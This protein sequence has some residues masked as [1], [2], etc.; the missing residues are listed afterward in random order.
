MTPQILSFIVLLLP[1]ILLCRAEWT[2]QNGNK[3][4][5]SPPPGTVDHSPAGQRR[6]QE[7][8]RAR[9]A[10]EEARHV[11]E[12]R[13]FDE[14][15]AKETAA[16]YAFTKKYKDYINSIGT[17]VKQ[18]Q[19]P[20]ELAGIEARRSTQA[21]LNQT[22]DTLTARYGRGTLTNHTEFSFCNLQ[23]TVCT[24]VP[25]FDTNRTVRI[26]AYFLDGKVARIVYFCE[27]YLAFSHIMSMSRF[28]SIWYGIVARATLDANA[29][30]HTWTCLYNT[31]SYGIDG[32]TKYVRDDLGATSEQE[33]N[34]KRGAWLVYE[35]PQWSKTAQ[36]MK[37]REH[38]REKEQ[39]RK[40][41][42]QRPPL[43]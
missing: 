19:T 30:G 32:I 16:F 6:A 15:S 8:E 20:E 41:Q 23:Y 18:P 25:S 12:R 1:G 34:Y 2:D 29:E 21:R 11:E 7:E 4:L 39:E 13:K 9:L 24:T 35:S 27:P 22:L 26:D 28:T 10:A 40:L 42:E 33:Y 43:L 3:H 31:E 36:A 37:R 14:E 5:G 17:A 38:E